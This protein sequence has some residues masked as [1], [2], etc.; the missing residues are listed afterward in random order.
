MPKSPSQSSNSHGGPRI[1]GRG[2]SQGRPK[3]NLRHPIHR[4][5]W[6]EAEMVEWLKSQGDE[7]TVLREIIKER[8]NENTN[9]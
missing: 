7:G 9:F 2:K 6:L 4:S 8:I 5:Y 3:L 1:P